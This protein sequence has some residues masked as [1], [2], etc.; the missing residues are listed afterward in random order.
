[1]TCVDLPGHGLSDLSVDLADL[2]AVCEALYTP[3]QPPVIL[4]GWSLGGLIAMAYALNYP[5]AVDRL[6]LVAASPRFVYADDWKYA[7]QAEVLEAFGKSLEQDYR[8]TLDRF[9]LLQVTSSERKHVCLRGL[10]R[11][12]YSHPPQKSALRAGLMLLRETDLRSRLTEIHCPTR[13]L[14]GERDSLIRRRSGQEI[15]SKLPD[16]RCVIIPGAGHAP[17][18]SH[19]EEFLRAMQNCLDD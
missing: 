10:R 12:L 19:P 17:F 7:I 5:T 11:V 6:L 14:L 1:L 4:V 13:I 2:D 3:A 18:L 8:T 16:G 9:L 15:V